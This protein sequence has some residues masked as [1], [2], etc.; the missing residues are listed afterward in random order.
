M[1]P[2]RRSRLVLLLA[3]GLILAG[4]KEPKI[5]AYR[6]PKDS[7]ADQPGAAPSRAANTNDLPPDARGG[8]AAAPL[9]DGPLPPGH[10]PIDGSTAPAPAAADSGM[11]GP[12]V[13]PVGDQA[14][15]WTAPAQWTPKTASAMRKGSYTVSGPEGT[16][17]LSITAFPGDVGGNLANV[18]RW[19]GQLQLP[20]VPDLAGALQPVE[21]NGLHLLVFDGANSGTRMLGAIV[22]LAGETWFF[23][24]TGPDALVAREKPAFLAFLTTVKAP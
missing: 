9:A 15:V 18:N 20:P 5:A 14:L 24:L 17:D 1:A 10:P 7:G 2:H 19:R 3:A 16:A 11:A 8:P 13:Q 23:K 4:C 6:V 12:Q 22:P 21:A